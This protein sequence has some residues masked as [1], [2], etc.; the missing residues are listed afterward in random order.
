[1]SPAAQSWRE[2]ER[3]MIN[4]TDS[5]LDDLLS[6][7]NKGQAAHLVL[8]AERRAALCNFDDV[9][10]CP[11]SGKT[12]LVGLKLLCLARRWPSAQRG[13]CVLAHTNVAKDEILK[14]L[15]R[16]PAGQALRGYPHF[17][18]T[19]QE[20]V[21][22]FLALPSLRSDGAEVRTIDD[23]QCEAK[24][25]RWASSKTKSYLAKKFASTSE[26]RY[27]WINENL[28]LKTPAFSGPSNSDSYK[29]L[30]KIKSRLQKEGS[31][32]FSEMYAYARKC[33]FQNP[34]ILVSLRHRFPVVL[35]D[36]MQDVQ[37]FQDE[38]INSIFAHPSVSYQRFGDP[39]QAIFDGVGGELPNTTYNSVAM[40][41]IAQSHRYCPSI[42]GHLRGLSS[43]KLQL[44]TSCA[45]A[46]EGPANT[47][48]LFSDATRDQVLER[49]GAEVL[50]LP[51]GRRRVVTALGGVAENQGDVASPLNI[52]SYWSEFTRDV[53]A[54]PQ[55]PATL[56]QAIRHA[57]TSFG[58][59]DAPFAF[60]CDAVVEIYGLA[61]VKFK[62]RAGNETSPS[63]FGLF[64]HLRAI[65]VLT[66]FRQIVANWMLGPEPTEQTWPDFVQNLLEILAV[67]A[68]LV[69]GE[70]Y[71]AYDPSQF[72]ESSELPTSKNVFTTADGLR[73]R[74]ATIHS[75]KGE[76]HDATLLMETKYRKLFDVKEML[77]HLLDETLAAPAFDAAHPTTNTSIKATFMKKAFVAASR[78]RHFLA[79]AMGRERITDSQRQDLQAK[80]WSIVDLG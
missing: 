54:S 74:L 65:Q 70:D 15:L 53:E 45:P 37:L 18:G 76:T 6:V 28:E 52:G 5:D 64:G 63:R 20:F 41:P 51:E 32:F 40:Q 8:D 71:L 14:C 34:D 78:P 12:T 9:Q 80:G 10:A 56:C 26:L 7:L 48:F 79:L 39:D 4:L 62:N 61:G 17:V 60:I 30:L 21:N 2:I 11:G 42:A 3:T 57:A 68:D 25:N 72:V 19:I 50:A 33:L 55:R 46:P 31:Y 58:A 35:I 29:D 73:I 75:V 13:I 24:L 47:M 22:T 16:H 23:A 38:L 27:Q 1:M 66:Q 69:V 44:T 36:E 59:N 77:P 49:F 67:P 43:R